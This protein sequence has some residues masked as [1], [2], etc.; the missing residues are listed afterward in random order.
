MS[1]ASVVV[2]LGPIA[3]VVAAVAPLPASARFTDEGSQATAPV[4]RVVLTPVPVIPLTEAGDGQPHLGAPAQPPAIDDVQTLDVR[5]GGAPTALQPAILRAINQVRA[6]HGLRPAPFYPGI[7][8][9]VLGLFLSV[10]AVRDTHFVALWAADSA[11]S[12]RVARSI[13]VAVSVPVPES[14]PG[15]GRVIV[16]TVPLRSANGFFNAPRIF[17]KMFQQMGLNGP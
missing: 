3:L 13:P 10:F 2:R 17:A 15:P 9:A 14:P 6:A 1:F 7:A 16:F 5:V 8:F 12:P 11:L 4:V